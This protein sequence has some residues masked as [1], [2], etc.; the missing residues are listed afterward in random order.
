MRN[1]LSLV[2]IILM[3][4]SSWFLYFY[5]TYTDAPR[6]VALL[7]NVLQTSLVFYCKK[8]SS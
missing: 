4:V 2:M 3:Q 1:F 6:N 7:G 8:C 5:V